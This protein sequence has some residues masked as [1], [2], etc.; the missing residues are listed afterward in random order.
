[1]N[2]FYLLKI[3]YNLKWKIKKR[4]A[5]IKKKKKKKKKIYKN[6]KKKKKKKK[7]I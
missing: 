1:M 7:N 6:K 3:I 2:L 5:D 4:L